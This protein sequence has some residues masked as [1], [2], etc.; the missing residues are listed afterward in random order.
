[1]APDTHQDFQTALHAHQRGDLTTAAT[2]YQQVLARDPAHLNAAANLSTLY[3]ATHHVSEALPLL[4]HALQAHPKEPVLHYNY[5]K[6]QLLLRKP[7]D[8]HAHFTRAI[9]LDQNNPHFYGGRGTALYDLG[10]YGEAV[11]DYDRALTLAPNHAEFYNQRGNAYVHLMQFD[12][13]IADYQKTTALASGFPEVHYNWSLLELM[14][15]EY[16]SGW[17]RHER[18]WERAF[19]ARDKRNFTQPLWLGQ[20][21]LTDKTILLYPEQGLGDVIH[22]ARYAPLLAAK[23]ARVIL[24]VQAPLVALMRTLP[25]TIT[26]IARGETLPAF[27]YHCPLLSLPL[28]FRTTLE[29]IPHTVPYLAADAA[30]RD[31]WHARLGPQTQPRIG[32]AWSGSAI[33]QNDQHR[34]MALETLAP[35]FTLPVQFHSLQKEVRDSDLHAYSVLIDHRDALQ[36]FTDTAALIDAMDLVISVDTSV[37]HL[38]GALAKPTWLMITAIPDFRWLLGRS[39]SPWYPTVELFRQPQPG[40][41]ASVVEQLRTRLMHYA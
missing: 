28:A 21:A 7:Q 2:Y 25:A 22:F 39:D 38:A 9:A 11:T 18:R 5:G 24:E 36:D 41:W 30:K 40:D 6:L 32:L 3:I 20:P 19:F 26:V 4:L 15:G 8:A 23:G 1:M 10:R 29:T 13:A 16:A 35:L 17:A 34:S 14:L 37:A 33:H 27:D 12:K 31:A